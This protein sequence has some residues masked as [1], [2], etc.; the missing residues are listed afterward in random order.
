MN[1]TVPDY[2]AMLRD[3][4]AGL[5]VNKAAHNHALRSL[6]HDR[7]KGS[8]EFKQANISAVLALHG[9]PYGLGKYFPFNVTANEVRCSEARPDHRA[10]V[11]RS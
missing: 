3:E 8:V 11:Q 6:L 2:I 9:C 7:S 1:P 10:F 4:L 5:P